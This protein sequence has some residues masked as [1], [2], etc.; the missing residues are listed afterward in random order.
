MGSVPKL[1]DIIFPPATCP[2]WKGLESSTLL[3]QRLQKFICQ[4]TG[5][6]L[7]TFAA[8]KQAIDNLAR[9]APTGDKNKGF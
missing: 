6:Q 7:L 4:R 5:L 8:A 3:Q 1:K 2:S 9:D